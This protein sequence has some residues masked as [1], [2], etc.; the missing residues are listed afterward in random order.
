MSA[1]EDSHYLKSVTSLG[2]TREVVTNQ[3]IYSRTGIK[4]ASR[5]SRINSSFYDRLVRHKLMPNLDECMTVEGA[6]STRE[7][8]SRAKALFENDSPLSGMAEFVEMERLWAI[9]S[10]INLNNALSFK[11]TVAREK[12]PEILEHSLRIMLLSL[13]IGL[14]RDLPESEMVALATA[15][16]FHD[17]GELHID[18]EILDKQH[19]LTPDE[20]RHIYA[21]PMT[22]HVILK[23]FPIY[24]PLISTAVLEHHEYLDGS[25]YP[26][27]LPGEKIGH[28][29]QILGI[30]E[31]TG[32][33]R[34]RERLEIV[35]KLNKHKLN[36][37][38]IG[39]VSELFRPGAGASGADRN[40][41]DIGKTLALLAESFDEWDKLC[42]ARGADT[43]IVKFANQR[44]QNLRHALFDAG[45]NPYEPGWLISGI[46]DDP[47]GLLD[48]E[49]LISE[50]A[51]QLKSLVRELDRF[52]PDKDGEA[53]KT[54]IGNCIQK[55]VN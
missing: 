7:L 46:E 25:G 41:G 19:A 16:A 53:V 12:R 22:A 4:L 3:D 29:S 28:L 55:M 31:V 39:L 2:D 17:L 10:K 20:R 50:S 27:G 40:S 49:A 32:G 9:V 47:E 30:A 48:V 13:Y 37:H 38:L 5:G 51:W 14:R 33:I 54:W 36:T 44:I 26:A 43:P 21:H 35:L 34:N 18:P 15:A 1:E 11:L 45:F 8:L 52:W 6:V 42:H 24:H 23:G